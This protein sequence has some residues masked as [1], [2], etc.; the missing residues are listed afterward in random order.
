MIADIP[1]SEPPASADL[2]I[3]Q[4]TLLLLH[5]TRCHLCP[6]V[7]A[8]HENKKELDP[9]APS[10]DEKVTQ[11]IAD[12]WPLFGSHTLAGTALVAGLHLQHCS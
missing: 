5:S 4:V 6:Q 3:V 7:G 2:L 11:N 10:S 12:H 8:V 9:S 1:G